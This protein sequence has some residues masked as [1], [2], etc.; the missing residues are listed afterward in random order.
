[1]P[2]MQYNQGIPTEVGV[3]ACRIIDPVCSRLIKD[4]FLI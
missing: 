3:Y 1:M 2:T 4:Q